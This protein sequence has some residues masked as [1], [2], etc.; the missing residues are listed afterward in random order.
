VSKAVVEKSP[1][2][3][4]LLNAFPLIMGLGYLYLNQW[5]RFL[6]AF[7]LQIVL[8]FLMARGAPELG[9]GLT[10]LWIITMLDARKQARATLRGP[11]LPRADDEGDDGSATRTGG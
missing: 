2:L 8:G 1:G 11:V 5:R 4:T 6:F 3:A 10:I 7:G 9:A